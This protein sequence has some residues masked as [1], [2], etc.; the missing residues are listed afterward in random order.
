MNYDTVVEVYIHHLAE[1]Q[2][3]IMIVQRQKKVVAG[4]AFIRAALFR[5]SSLVAPDLIS[6]TTLLS[7]TSS[8][9]TRLGVKWGS[10]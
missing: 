6:L 8:T 7:R 3:N 4:I 1:R 10:K 5:P 2:V 9:P